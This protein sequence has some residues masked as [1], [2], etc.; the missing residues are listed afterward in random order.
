MRIPWAV[1]WLDPPCEM[2]PQGHLLL[3][4]LL[5]SKWAS[6]QQ[7]RP[8]LRLLPRVRDTDWLWLQILFSVVG[9][10]VDGRYSTDGGWDD[11]LRRFWPGF[12]NFLYQYP[13]CL[14]FNFFLPL[15]SPFQNDGWIKTR[16]IPKGTYDGRK[17]VG[18]PSFG[19]IRNS[20]AA[21]RQES[22]TR[23]RPAVSG[24]ETRGCYAVLL[25]RTVLLLKNQRHDYHCH[26]FITPSG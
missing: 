19:K 1:S 21:L 13:S 20:S 10:P 25:L 15:P 8:S 14:Q 12:E 5:A 9:E 18:I 23:R 26:I 3:G 2:R 24:N 6:E 7:R 11:N 22:N 16:T 17:E 4:D